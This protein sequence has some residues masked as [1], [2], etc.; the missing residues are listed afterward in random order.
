MRANVNGLTQASNEH[1]RRLDR[2][3]SDQLRKSINMM[4]NGSWIGWMF[5]AFLGILTGALMAVY[6]YH[7]K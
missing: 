1:N 3:E 5:P 6:F 2:M 4:Q 7:V